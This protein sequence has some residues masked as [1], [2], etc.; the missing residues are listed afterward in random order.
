MTRSV[1]NLMEC[2]YTSV[3]NNATLLVNIPPNKKGDLPKKFIKRLQTVSRRIENDFAERVDCKQKQIDEYTYEL[4]FN[5]SCIQKAILR[6]D[7][8]QSQRV[9]KFEIIANGVT[10][11]K[12]E[13]IGY[14]KICFFNS[15][16]TNKIIVK[17]TQS[18]NAP[19]LL[20]TGLYK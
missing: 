10:V 16:K 12:G 14:K 2:Y 6:E 19:V 9:E 4:N 1:K 5:T 20:E 15:V 7:I 11:F 8:T 18:R 3:G 17:I 13:T